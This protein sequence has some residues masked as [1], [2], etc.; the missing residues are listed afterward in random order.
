[1]PS[2]EWITTVDCADEKPAIPVA[3]THPF[4]QREVRAWDAQSDAAQGNA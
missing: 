3:V 2:S 4:G 1:M